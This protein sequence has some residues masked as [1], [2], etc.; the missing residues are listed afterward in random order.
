MY[1]IFDV[2]CTA[3]GF[4]SSDRHVGWAW[5]LFGSRKAGKVFTYFGPPSHQEVGTVAD[6]LRDALARESWRDH[7]ARY[8]DKIRET[9]EKRLQE[10]ER[11]LE[12]CPDVEIRDP[13]GNTDDIYLI[14][15]GDICVPNMQASRECPRCGQ[16]TLDLVD[17]GR[18]DLDR[19]LL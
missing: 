4:Q 8:R 7:P 18:W 14:C 5:R 15:S 16:Q 12:E 1:P 17:A 3:C 11:L 19:S 10:C 6:S 2:K 13:L 9:W